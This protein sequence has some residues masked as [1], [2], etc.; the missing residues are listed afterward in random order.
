MIFL[1]FNIYIFSGIL[2]MPIYCNLYRFKLPLKVIQ[3]I[4]KCLEEKTINQWEEISFL[5]C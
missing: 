1:P 2:A 5:G 4:F 3:I